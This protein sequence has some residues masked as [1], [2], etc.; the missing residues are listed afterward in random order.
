[1]KTYT[2]ARH[3]HACAHTSMQ[4]YQFIL[5]AI[6]TLWQYIPYV[7]PIIVWHTLFSKNSRFITKFLFTGCNTSPRGDLRTPQEET[8]ETS[9]WCSGLCRDRLFASLEPKWIF[10]EVR[11]NIQTSTSTLHNCKTNHIVNFS[12]R[13]RHNYSVWSVSNRSCHIVYI[14]NFSKRN[15]S[16]WMINSISG[17]F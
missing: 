8:G 11:T 14:Q 1:M 7:S 15:I 12:K 17:N 5:Q 16:F 10:S 9:P 3:M 2:H 13:S 6:H 4:T